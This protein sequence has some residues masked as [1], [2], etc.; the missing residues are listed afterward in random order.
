MGLGPEQGFKTRSAHENVTWRGHFLA[1][2]LTVQPGPSSVSPVE[3]VSHVLRYP[4][5]NG[6]FIRMEFAV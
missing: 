6:Y 1:R 5:H 2:H 4:L 3:E